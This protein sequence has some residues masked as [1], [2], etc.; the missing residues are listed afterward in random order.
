VVA[1]IE[2]LTVLSRASLLPDRSGHDCGTYACVNNFDWSGLAAHYSGVIQQESN[3]E[4][5]VIRVHSGKFFS[6]GK[7]TG[8]RWLRD[9]R[10]RVRCATTFLILGLALLG[11]FIAAPPVTAQQQTLPDH[12]ANPRNPVAIENCQPG[13][14]DWQIKH[15]RADGQ[16]EG[17]ASATSVN[18]GESLDFFINT[19]ARLFQL[20]IYRTGFYNGA[21][22]RL[23]LDAGSL[24]GRQQPACRDDRTTG[25]TSCSNWTS[26][27]RLT[28]PPGWV[29]GVYLAKLS[30]P[31]TGAENYILFVVRDDARASDIL[32]QQSVLTYQAYNYYGGKALY[33]SPSWQACPTV[34]EQTRASMV[35]LDRPYLASPEEFNMYF[36]VEYPMV[37]WLEEQGYDVTYSTDV[38][39][40]RAGQPGQPNTLRDHRVLL[41]SGHDE[42]WTQGMRDATTAA[43]DAGVNL[44]V[45]SANTGYWR[46]RL[47]P[48][49]Y[50]G[51]PDRTLVGYKTAQS[52]PPDPS[53]DPT[54]TWRD[55]QGPN[56]PENAL[57]GVQYIGDND[58][59]FF[60]L[61]VTAEQA[62]D[63]L[64]RHTGLQDLPAGT[65]AT[66]G[67]Q[68]IGWEW[69]ATVQN[70]Q[71]PA[72]LR[73]LASSPVNG[74]LLEDA[75][76]QY[77]SVRTA[78]AETTRYVAPS[79]AI[80][81]SAGTIQW[82]FGL[83]IVEPN[84]IIQQITAN[85]LA[86]MGT[87]PATPAAT[88]AVDGSPQPPSTAPPIMALTPGAPPRISNIQVNAGATSVTVQ[89]ATDTATNGQVWLGDTPATIAESRPVTLT[90]YQRTHSLTLPYL[91]PGQTYYFQIIA[92][93]AAGN[94]SIT[95]A[96]ATA[97]FQTA[98]GSLALRAKG[99]A[100]S[101]IGGCGCWIAGHQTLVRVGGVGG[102][103]VIVILAGRVLLALYRRRARRRVSGQARLAPGQPAPHPAATSS[104]DSYS[105]K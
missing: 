10:P 3:V 71:T 42:Y 24:A 75:G 65:Y 64:Y 6:H 95:P 13:T 23:L 17:F 34:T 66:I 16:L 92:A 2:K 98:P 5:R 41:I 55:P 105:A 84:P 91:D 59:F 88:L 79:G 83:A 38:D 20:R 80:V 21:G 14:P 43:R 9:R 76:R 40:N 11:W 35:S 19:T 26:S 82:A 12:C 39:T 78:V 8:R 69:D 37:R 93:D 94:T 89:W 50:S 86:D 56:A 74:E 45:F 100:K 73:V 57:F 27:Y 99:T 1:A 7:F 29:S 72:N 61:R 70:G 49:P 90:D 44:A 18:I 87:Q 101:L 30:R 102:A 28:T 63:R 15:Y 60:P 36:H 68:L 58:T 104:G 97:Q 81:F 25:L 85:L 32:Y 62:Q 67:K 53:G 48:D 77:S 54:T 31:D 51:K 103:L 22:G 46:V 4:R 33:N 96:S 52:G 47:A